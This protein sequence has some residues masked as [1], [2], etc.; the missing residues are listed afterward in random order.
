MKTR[1]DYLEDLFLA[2]RRHLMKRVSEDTARWMATNITVRVEQNEKMTIEDIKKL[3][4][5]FIYRG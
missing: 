1:K 3:R 2:V 4:D 5:E